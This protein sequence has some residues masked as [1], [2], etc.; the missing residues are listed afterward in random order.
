MDNNKD[1]K[2]IIVNPDYGQLIKHQT[3]G[4]I[5]EA[6]ISY[7]FS[8]NNKFNK[9]TVFVIVR[10]MIIVVFLKIILE[11]SKTYL[12]KFKFTDLNIFKYVYQSIVCSEIRYSIIKIDNKWVWDQKVISINTL[13]PFLEQKKIYVSQHGT[14]FFY[15]K[16]YLVKVIISQNEI[17]FC[18]PNI[19]FMTRYI[20]LEVIHKNAEVL[21]GKTVISKVVITPSFILKLEPLQLA[22]A[23]AT[24]NYTKL[25]NS[26]R[27]NFLINSVLNFH[28][29]P[30]CVNFDGE[31][32]TGKTSFS[33]YIAT[34][35]I[36][37]R[38]LVYNMVGSHYTNLQDLL[39]KLETQIANSSK[40]KKIDEPEKVL[41]IFDEMDKW[42][43][44][45][46]DCQLQKYI[47]EQ[48]T[49]KQSKANEETNKIEPVVYCLNESEK[50]E[51]KIQIK[52]DFFDQLYKLVDGHLFSDTRRYVLIFNTNNFN[53]IFNG[54]DER[55]AALKDRFQRYYFEKIGR[56]D[57]KFYLEEISK[58][59][60][61]FAETS[62]T[63]K[64]D[65]TLLDTLCL[66]P[67]DIFE[68][69]PQNLKI[70]YRS[71]LK[72]L[73]THCFNIT[74]TVYFL[75]K[76]SALFT[77]NQLQYTDTDK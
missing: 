65:S 60:Q 30:Y 63:K 47:T 17:V 36:F 66:Y 51:K 52:N 15:V 12:D 24:Q 23:F 44:S 19:A 53:N 28:Q 33:S 2:N 27:I 37:D 21:F 20:E 45:F 13:T 46:L 75:E 40:D 39:V 69:I 72:I 3:N 7:L 74:Q 34:T 26:I 38:I 5:V 41:I 4:A 59:L 70:S 1:S 14:Y 62:T 49:M 9:T 55:Y 76:N 31:P 56:S 10:N 58:K 18:I 73:R 25:E 54:A 64:I 48:Q 71:L 50:L 67:D 22:H 32:G 8:K 43:V 61:N 77:D 42:L 35:S 16:N 68:K 57:I 11:E 29:A 6:F